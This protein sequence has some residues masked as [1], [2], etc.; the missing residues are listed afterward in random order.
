[1]HLDPG[2]QDISILSSSSDKPIGASNNGIDESTP[3][4]G[5]E[6]VE[7]IIEAVSLKVKYFL[8]HQEEFQG[9][10]SPM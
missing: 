1:M 2:M 5:K 9:H 3:G 10:G 8:E 6:A 4:F 7:G